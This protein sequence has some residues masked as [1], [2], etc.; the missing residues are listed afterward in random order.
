MASAPRRLEVD[1]CMA[2]DEVSGTGTQLWERRA[3]RT[4]GAKRHQ[5]HWR[6]MLMLMIPHY[7]MSVASHRVHAWMLQAC[8]QCMGSECPQRLHTAEQ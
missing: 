6:R 1:S 7:H 3:L 2:S 4:L 5:E 8:R